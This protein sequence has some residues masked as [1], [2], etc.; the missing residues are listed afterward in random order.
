VFRRAAADVTIG[1]ASIAAG[2]RVVLMLAA[3]NRDPA[4][5]PD[6]D[7]LDLARRAAGH[8]AFGLGAHV[9]P[10]APLIRLAVAVATEALL[11]A[12]DAIE[13]AGEVEWLGGFA[14]RAPATLPVVLRRG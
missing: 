12:A 6:P 14:I 4:R 5:F 2:E 7:R 10:G 13:P 9:C 1:D 8:L 11:G 3:A